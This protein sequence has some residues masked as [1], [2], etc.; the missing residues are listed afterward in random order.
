MRTKNYPNELGNDVK[1]NTMNILLVDD[2]ENILKS[3]GNFLRDFGHE[4]MT[5]SS[6]IEALNQL[7]NLPD[8]RVELVAEGPPA[9]VTAFL[10]D[11]SRTMGDLVRD[12]SS[13]P[14]PV[15]GGF[16][17]FGIR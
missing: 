10:L 15:T 6:S 1:G 17:G 8:G 9:D 7:K 16:S 3:I 5:F 14:R 11:V 13:K 2:E 4:V 12:Q